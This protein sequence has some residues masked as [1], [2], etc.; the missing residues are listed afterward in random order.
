M[1][2]EEKVAL[3]RERAKVSDSND[4]GSLLGYLDIQY[5]ELIDMFGK[6]NR[7]T[8]GYKIDA[9]WGIKFDNVSFSI[10]NYKDGINYNGEVDGLPV[11]MIT[12]WHVGGRDKEKAAEFIKL[13]TENR[14]GPY[15]IEVDVED[16]IEKIKGLDSSDLIHLKSF[17]ERV[18][19]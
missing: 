18:Y 10:Y 11:E 15:K 5:N 9:E 1:T 14:T 17:I 6:P 4:G 13:I 7:D 16:I 3:I 8:D 2:K 12:E 19:S